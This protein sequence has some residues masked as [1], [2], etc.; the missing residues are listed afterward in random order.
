VLVLVG[1]YLGAGK[2]T[3]LLRAAAELRRSGVRVALITNDQGATLVDTRLAVNSGIETLEITGGCFCCRLSEFAG[4]AERLLASEP[5]V[6]F[7]EPVGSCIDIAATVVRPLQA[8]WKH[9]FRAAPFTVLVDPSRARELIAPDADPLPAYL[10]RNQLAEADLICISKSDVYP[11]LRE[12]AGINAMRLSAHTGEGVPEWLQ[13]VLAGSRSAGAR[14]L[15]VD[16]DRYADAEA[17]LG[18]LNWEGIVHTQPAVS[19]AVLVGPLLEQLDQELTVA[20][21][22]LARL[23]I[24]DESASGS[25]KAAICANGEEPSVE[26]SL[27]ASPTEHHDILLNL[28]ASAS[29]EQLDA[30]V[31]HAIERLPGK[32]TTLQF[33]CFRPARP[34]PERRITQPLPAVRA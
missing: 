34:R 2:T 16:Y 13:E 6:I 27:D 31:R 18:W 11:D 20:G 26:G 23:K 17:A 24:L 22:G 3:L 8:S 1:G 25:V 9:R 33:E 29:P 5:D 30:V 19:P 14:V 15:D 7:A 28:R 10:F 32:A 12:L 21:I 4:A